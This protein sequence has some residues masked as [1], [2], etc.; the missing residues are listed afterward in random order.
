MEG[1]FTHFFAASGAA[2]WWDWHAATSTEPWVGW[3][4]IFSD[5]VIAIAC[6][7]IPLMLVFYRVRGRAV[8]YPK[9]LMLFALLLLACGIGRGL[10]AIG[11]WLPAYQ[12]M[13]LVN[14]ATAVLSAITAVAVIYATRNALRLRSPADLEQQVRQRTEQLRHA[15]RLTNDANVLF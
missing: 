9:T 15:N 12:L 1:I 8:P 5:L 2:T 10:G 4:D 11:Y 3:V 14:L 6:I 7:I 13:V